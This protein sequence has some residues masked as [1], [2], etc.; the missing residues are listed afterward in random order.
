[1]VVEE[2]KPAEAEEPEPTEAEEP[3]GY[4]EESRTEISPYFITYDFN[5][6]NSAKYDQVTIC[7]IGQ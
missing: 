6:I 4:N 5:F 1:M 3:E 2:P 7:E